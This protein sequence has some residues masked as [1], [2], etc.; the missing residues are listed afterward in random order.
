MP[1]LNGK[2]GNRAQGAGGQRPS[3]REA[4]YE[5]LKDRK[6][7]QRMKV[8]ELKE[9]P[10]EVLQELAK[11]KQRNGNASSLAMK[12]QRILFCMGGRSFSRD[13]NPQNA[14]R[15]PKCHVQGHN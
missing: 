7:Y 15:A 13:H 12:A 11:L 10:K 3:E 2:E 9:L 8:E 5:M 6:L 1:R 14:H 4:V